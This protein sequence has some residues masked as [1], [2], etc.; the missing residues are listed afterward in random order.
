MSPLPIRIAI[1]D[2]ALVQP[3]RIRAKYGN[4][5]NAFSILLHTAADALDL[6]RDRL[7]LS[8]WDVANGK[9]EGV[10]VYPTLSE[11]DAVLITGSRES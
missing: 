8:A 10:G 9:S 11:V 7:K 6:P 3:P 4:M 2:T 5:A 1:L